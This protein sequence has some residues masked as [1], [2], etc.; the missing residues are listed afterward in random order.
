MTLSI[1]TWVKQGAMAMKGYFAFYKVAALQ[2]T[3]Y[4]IV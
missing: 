3:H 4:Q 1:A 2:E